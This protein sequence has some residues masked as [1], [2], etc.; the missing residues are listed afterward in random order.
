VQSISIISP[1]LRAQFGHPSG[2]FGRVAGTIMANRASNRERA[3][4]SVG[5]LGIEAHDRVLE[6]G[7]GPGVAIDI[8][9]RAA[10]GVLVSGIDH[11]E[12]VLR[13]AERR[14][15]REVLNRRR[16]GIEGARSGSVRGP[17]ST[18]ETSLRFAL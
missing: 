8:A 16:R 14:N 9:S 10:P 4:W 18:C 15:A 1:W 6:I 2:L 17:L 3:R 5:L 12:I 13:Q 11:S 7:F